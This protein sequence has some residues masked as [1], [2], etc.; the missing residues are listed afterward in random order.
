MRNP[1]PPR[2]SYGHFG[3]YFAS[4]GEHDLLSV[5]SIIS[6]VLLEL[7]KSDSEDVSTFGEEEIQKYFGVC[8]FAS[9]FRCA[10]E[11]LNGDT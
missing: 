1:N 10:E 4:S 6:Q 5:A 3:F 2:P 11:V 8:S 9:H 7:G